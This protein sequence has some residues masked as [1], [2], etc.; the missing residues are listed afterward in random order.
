MAKQHKTG[1]QTQ[2]IIKDVNERKRNVSS[3]MKDTYAFDSVYGS[4]KL[5]S[6][7][8]DNLEKRFDLVL[9]K[10][11]RNQKKTTNGT[12]IFSGI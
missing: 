8:P 4:Y 6:K 1:R 2:Q 9:I 10:K 11:T 3:R 7:F 5:R 12:H